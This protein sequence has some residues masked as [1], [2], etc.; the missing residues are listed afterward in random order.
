MPPVRWNRTPVIDAMKRLL[1]FLLAVSAALT[2]GAQILSVEGPDRVA[3]YGRA[4]FTIVLQGTWNNPYLQEE[5][6]LDLVLTAP[7]GKT[8]VLPCF[9]VEGESGG[10]SRWGARF[11]P[12]EQGRYGY[13][14]VY[15]ERGLPVSESQQ[16]TFEA[17]KPAGH[18]IL[19]PR[20]NWTLAYDDG[21]PFRGIAENI[22]WESRTNDDSK[23]FKALHERH[24]KY[25]YDVML[26]QFAAAG[27]NFCRLWMC[28]WNFPIDRHRNF[29]NFRYTESDEYFNPSAVARLDHTVELGE[30]LGIHFMLCM[31][32]GD[33]RT[34]HDFFISEA[35]KARHRNYLRYIVAR[36]GYSPAIGM[37]EFFNEI[38]NIQFRDERNPIPAAD[39]VAWHAEMAAY[40][41]SIDPF[42]HIVTT[43]ISHRDLEGLNDVKDL[44][45]NQKHIYCATSSIPETIIRYEKAH[46]KPYVIGEFSYE[47]DW[48]KNFDDFGEEMDL[49]FKR[50]LWYGLFSPTPIT[51]MSWWWEYFENRGLVPY[52]Q[53]VRYVNDRMLK[54]GKGSFEPVEVEADG[55]EAFAVRF[56]GIIYVYACNPSSNPVSTLRIPVPRALRI[57]PK[58]T[59]L[60]FEKHRFKGGK[61][62][63]P[64]DGVLSIPVDLVPRSEVL[65]RIENCQ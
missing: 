54:F 44:D 7:S 17:G 18:G 1:S 3:E 50:G 42:G 64:K 38:D 10:Q 59:P 49:D 29:N 27:G 9:F 15:A 28:S 43:S 51:P 60:D 57:A 53:N 6:T 45:I 63:S 36:W 41:K 37:W 46:G 20:D 11:T 61:R 65:F 58:V 21:T 62:I 33:A 55:A 22:C 4:D 2:A 8:L 35:A 48:S 13:T 30:E 39:I 24:D 16:G 52:F 40:L 25:N 19:H 26:P 23:F 31:G 5:V 56:G 47:W 14:L 32:P 12:Q 34:D